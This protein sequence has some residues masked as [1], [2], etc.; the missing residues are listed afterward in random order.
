MVVKFAVAIA[1]ALTVPPVANADIGI[2]KVAPSHAR[3]GD[4]IR[5][6]AQG[7]LGMTHQPFRCARASGL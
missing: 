3:Q 2:V 6:T 7:Y 1:I 4:L 5:V